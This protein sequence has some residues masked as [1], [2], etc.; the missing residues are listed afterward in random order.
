MFEDQA[1]TAQPQRVKASARLQH[2]AKTR[3]P[4]SIRRAHGRGIFPWL[5][6]PQVEGLGWRFHRE[7]WGHQ[8]NAAVGCPRPQ[9]HYPLRSGVGFRARADAD[10]DLVL[11]APLLDRLQAPMYRGK[12]KSTGERLRR[13]DVLHRLVR[14]LRQEQ[15]SCLRMGAS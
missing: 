11:L 6:A 9:R 7:P 5:K 4:P 1:C 10:D 14:S 12:F 2:R 8:R 15:L 3:P 13:G